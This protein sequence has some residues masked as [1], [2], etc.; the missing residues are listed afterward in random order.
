MWVGGWLG[1][2]SRQIITCGRE[3]AEYAALPVVCRLQKALGV[4]CRSIKFNSLFVNAMRTLVQARGC[5]PAQ[6]VSEGYE[7]IEV[8]GDADFE[9]FTPQ[10]EPVRLFVCPGASCARHAAKGSFRHVFGGAR[11]RAHKL[12]A[13][14]VCRLVLRRFAVVETADRRAHRCSALPWHQR[15]PAHTVACRT[16][17]RFQNDVHQ[18]PWYHHNITRRDAERLLFD[19]GQGIKG[20]YLI[21]PSQETIGDLSVSVNG[22]DKVKHFKVHLRHLSNDYLFGDR[23]F[24]SVVDLVCFYQTYS[25]FTT[26]QGHG[27]LMPCLVV[28]LLLFFLV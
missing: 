14:R 3:R 10:P 4:S 24:E 20:C 7:E 27:K 23:V 13:W 9:A 25:I 18:Y 12:L 5:L 1:D 8:V 17:A 2:R 28:N 15:R 11:I 22:G 26:A 6:Y 21:R 16:A 19:Q